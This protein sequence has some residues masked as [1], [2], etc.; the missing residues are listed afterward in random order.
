MNNP[1]KPFIHYLSCLKQ[2]L[3]EHAEIDSFLDSRLAEN[4]F[5]VHQQISTAIS[6]ALRC[7][8]PLIGTDVVSFHKNSTRMGLV[9]EID[10]TIQFLSDIPPERFTHSSIESV[11]ITAGFA[12]RTFNREDF[13]LLYAL[14]NF[15]FHISMAYAALRASGV[16]LGKTDFDQIHH[17]PDGFNF[18]D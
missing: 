2:V 4:M 8:C 7:C 18:E 1:S 12:E 14:P 9:A 5:P 13:V 16:L 11:T 6:F 10:K 17:Y 3:V 15:L